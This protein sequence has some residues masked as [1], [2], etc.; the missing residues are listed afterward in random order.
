MLFEEGME[1]L[2][3]ILPEELWRILGVLDRDAEVGGCILPR[4]DPLSRLPL[5]V[6]VL[7]GRGSHSGLRDLLSETAVGEEILSI[8]D[9]LLPRVC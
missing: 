2:G 1:G 4:K 5:E 9:H 7:D 8:W 3:P 6:K